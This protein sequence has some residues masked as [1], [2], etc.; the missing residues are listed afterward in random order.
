MSE[1]R[2]GGAAGSAERDEVVALF[3]A[4]VV[5]GD[6]SDGR[7]EDHLVVLGRAKSRLAAMD[8]E[9][10][11]ELARRRGEAEAVDLL[12]GKRKQ[13][14]GGAKREVQQA[15]R[16]AELPGTAQAL[17]EGR[18]TP[19]HARLI[20]EAAQV[21][22]GAG[23]LDEEA[24]LAAAA[25]EPADLFGRTVRD[26]INDR[27]G[28][29]LT[30]RRRR[31]RA[32]R[33]LTWKQ[34]PDGMFE[35]FGRFDPVTGSRIETA[36]GAVANKLW[37]AED[38]KNRRTPQQRMAD[39]LEVLATGGEGGGNAKGTPQ[40]VDLLVIA[41]YDTVLSQLRDARLVDG[42]LLSPEELSRLAC[43]A[44]ILPAL[45]NRKSEPLWL[46]RG[47]R[48]ASARQR[49]LLAER[50]K[51]CIGCGASASWCQA[52]HIRHWQHG[53]CTDLDNL[54]LLCSHCHHQVHEQG[55]QVVKDSNGRYGLQHQRR[56]PSARNPDL[57]HPRLC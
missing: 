22:P 14:R 7:L 48:H 26:H 17:E 32:Q 55:A 18:I 34:Q 12:R 27:S 6:L 24:L 2:R 46:G 39:A 31:Q 45:F 37:R 53:G 50:D 28:D 15:G 29:D 25:R 52:H 51:G 11:A 30:E 20:V 57:N 8:A 56:T 43:D 3:A 36:L 47:K 44:N 42:T 5:V 10:V 49:A 16:L 23:P 4:P 54:C 19:Q 1:G 41:D 9:A 21:A 13:S 40:G 38:P 33:R 35:M